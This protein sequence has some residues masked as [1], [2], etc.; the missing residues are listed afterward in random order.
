GW[1]HGARQGARR[2]V[3]GNAGAIPGY[4]YNMGVVIVR[5][6]LQMPSLLQLYVSERFLPAGKILCPKS[7][8]E[9][10]TRIISTLAIF[11]VP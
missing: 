11:L 1:R 2:G 6:P 9:Q 8:Q 5:S 3:G 7:N 4:L 10:K